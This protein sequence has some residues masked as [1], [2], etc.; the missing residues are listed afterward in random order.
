MKAVGS[1]NRTVAAAAVVVVDGPD[2]HQRTLRPTDTAGRSHRRLLDRCRSRASVYRGPDRRRSP[3]HPPSSSRPLNV[4]LG[5][6]LL[7]SVG[8]VLAALYV[9]PM[10][11]QTQTI[12]GEWLMAS[13]AVLAAL[14]G[15]VYAM[16]WRLVGDAPSLWVSAALFVYSFVSI[17]VPSLVRSF[18][19]GSDDAQTLAGLL[20]PT[21]VFLVVV[22]LLRALAAP[23]VD[24]GLTPRRVVA[25]AA[26]V[27]FGGLLA[28]AGSGAFRVVLGPPVDRVPTSTIAAFGQIGVGVVWLA[29]GAACLSRSSRRRTTV[30]PWIGIMLLSL[31]E[32]RLALAVS[33][34]QGPSWMFVSD[35]F[36]VVGVAAALAGAMTEIHIA[37]AQ[38]RS[39]LLDS[40][41]ELGSAQ[42]RHRA[43]QASQ[44]ERTHDVRAALAGIESATMTL[45]RYHDQLSRADRAKLATAVAAE[46]ARL[47]QIVGAVQDE[48]ARFALADTLRPVLL[49]AAAGG[50]PVDVDIPADLEAIG[51]PGA[52]AEALQ[53]LLDNARRH[54]PGSRAVVR[55]ERDGS[56]VALR[57]EDRGPGV[58]P[59]D[60]ERIFERGWRAHVGGDGSGLGLF[61]ASRLVREQGGQLWMEP[62]RGGGSSFVL[63]LPAALPEGVG[64]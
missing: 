35:L 12:G 2:L 43:E 38:Q 19:G 15:A 23:P 54:A 53:N 3:A 37:F 5:V 20:R 4:A 7:V 13:S 48:P 47:Q 34:M 58:P 16:R 56:I 49:C 14:A 10:E 52:V 8:I 32:G 44:A 11:P 41:L 29:L 55:A 30:S 39:Q 40:L 50:A 45:E 62:R 17:A 60:R 64:G 1:S 36:R 21:G 57:V 18:A 51:R 27:S 61:L 9:P 59:G 22:L 31:A 28:G 24:A 25:T 42:A 63:T 26:I 46:I 33:V 6:L